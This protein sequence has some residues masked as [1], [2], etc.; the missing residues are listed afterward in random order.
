MKAVKPVLD[1]LSADARA[2]VNS[3][4]F[5]DRVRNLGIFPQGDTPQEL[6]RWM[7]EQIA[8]WVDIAKAANIKAD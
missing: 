8:R 1:K 7:R 5:A 2:V 4:E 3:R 6:D